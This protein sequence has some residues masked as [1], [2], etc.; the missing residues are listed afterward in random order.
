MSNQQHQIKGQMMRIFDAHQ[1][2]PTFSVREF[3]II[4]DGRYPQIIKFQVFNDHCDTLD[5]Y[6]QDDLVLVTFEIRGRE[7]KD[8]VF[9]N[10]H[11]ISIARL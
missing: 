11:A 9:N 2:R 8:K 5:A 3:Y 4:T 1:K 6:R 7:H 10:L